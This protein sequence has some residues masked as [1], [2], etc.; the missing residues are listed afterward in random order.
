MKKLLSALIIAAFA[1]VSFSAVAAEATPATQQKIEAPAH[2][3][4]QK[5]AHKHHAKKA[6]VAA[7]SAAK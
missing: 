4:A 2:K 1:A 6:E 5:H 3:H 7:S